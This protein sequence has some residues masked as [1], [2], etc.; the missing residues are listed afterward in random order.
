MRVKSEGMFTPI[1]IST[2]NS[3]PSTCPSC[4]KQEDKKEVCRHCGYEYKDEISGIKTLIFWAILLIIV[5]LFFTVGFWLMQ[6][7]G[8]EELDEGKTLMQ[9]F[10]AQGQWFKNLKVF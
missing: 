4:N 3:A 8:P 6:A 2:S 5:H 10:Q 1:L 7:G 9:V